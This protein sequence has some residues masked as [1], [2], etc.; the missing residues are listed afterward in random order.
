MDSGQ[1]KI[2]YCLAMNSKRFA[3]LTVTR[4]GISN[5]AALFVFWEG[6]RLFAERDILLD[7]R[8]TFP[9]EGAYVMLSQYGNIEVVFDAVSQKGLAMMQK[10]YMKEMGHSEAQMFFSVD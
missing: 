3:A 9:G 5:P 2:P 4:P 8:L 1:H 6:L 7:L 10:K